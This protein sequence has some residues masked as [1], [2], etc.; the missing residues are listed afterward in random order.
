LFNILP[1]LNLIVFN[2]PNIFKTEVYL[3]L[4]N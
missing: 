3:K 2:Q 1:Q 4:H